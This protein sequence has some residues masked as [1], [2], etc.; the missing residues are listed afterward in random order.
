MA[1]VL[2]MESVRYPNTGLTKP[3]TVVLSMIC[4]TEYLPLNNFSVIQ[5]EVKHLELVN[6]WVKKKKRKK[7]D[8]T[9]KGQLVSIKNGSITGLILVVFDM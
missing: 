8:S 2:V 9:Y 7:R 1:V 5:N 3:S 4:T 6:G